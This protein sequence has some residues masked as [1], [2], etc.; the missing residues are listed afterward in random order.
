M[1]V[2]WW[3]AGDD[4]V[5]SIVFVMDARLMFGIIFLCQITYTASTDLTLNLVRSNLLVIN[6]SLKASFQFFLQQ[7]QDSLS[8]K[9]L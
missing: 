3:E 6:E 4:V 2:G 5:F 9:P 7:A 1:D 8:L